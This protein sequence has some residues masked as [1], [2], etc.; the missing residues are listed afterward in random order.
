MFENNK[1]KWSSV[2]SM[3]E[4]KGDKEKYEKFFRSA[5]KKFGVESPA[6]L[7][8]EKKKEFYDYVDKNYVGDHEKDNPNAESVE[9]V[10]EQGTDE[11]TEYLKNL[12]PGQNN[13]HHEKDENGNPI[14]HDIEEKAVSQ[15]QQKLMGL[16]YA[17]KKGE[18]DAPSPEIQKIADSMSLEEL[19]K[20]AE[21][22]HKDLP[23][24][25]EEN[26]TESNFDLISK[27]IN[28][29]RVYSKEPVAKTEKLDARKKMFREKIKKLA[30]EKAKKMVK[31]GKMEEKKEE[32]EKIKNKV[33]I[34]PELKEH[35]GYEFVKK[36]FDK[37][38]TLS[39]QEEQILNLL[40]SNP[41][42]FEL[43]GTYTNAVG[44]GEDGPERDMPI[45]AAIIAKTLKIS[46]MKVQEMLD[47]MVR[48]GMV[49]R[50]GDAYSFGKT[51]TY[52]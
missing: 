7:S 44:Y 13:I 1:K 16:A 10:H 2:Y 5:L 41:Y 40:E 36:Y 45:T 25:K 21:G 11:Y 15:Q 22:K 17:V 30:Y 20:M 32:K 12:T 51:E 49:T 52:T 31:S 4:E 3:L 35:K 8:P 19:K 27:N 47:K 46:P 39:E 6:E 9:E 24:K 34:N 43:A 37:Q 29:K 48:M 23:V 42:R 38:K 28:D 50:V 26:N 18:I 14:P 33:T